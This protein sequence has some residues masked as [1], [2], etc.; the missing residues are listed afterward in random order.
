MWRRPH[1]KYDVKC[2]IHTMK[3]GQDG[4]MVWGCFTKYGL[5]PLV[6]VKF[7]GR[8]TAK[9]YIAVLR[10]HLISDALYKYS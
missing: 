9:D 2:L 8:I 10:N 6:I 7:D 1:E 5:G 3:S 4:V